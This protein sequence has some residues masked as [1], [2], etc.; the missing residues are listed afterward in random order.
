MIAGLQFVYSCGKLPT[1]D[2][3][4]HQSSAIHLLRNV[5]LAGFDGDDEEEKFRSLYPLID[6]VILELM[7]VYRLCQLL[8]HRSLAARSSE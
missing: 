6:P 4:K 7:L 5:Y 2:H 3:D 1:H 8:P